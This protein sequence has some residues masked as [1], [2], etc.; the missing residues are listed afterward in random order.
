M[1]AEEQM[2]PECEHR[3]TAVEKD[4][5]YI[6]H[7]DIPHLAKEVKSIKRLIYAVLT[8][9]LTGFIGLIFSIIRGHLKF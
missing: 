2:R 4:I 6:R 8:S 9:I 3:F 7:N 5:Y 1:F